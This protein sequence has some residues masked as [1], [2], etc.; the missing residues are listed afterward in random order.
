MN[1]GTFQPNQSTGIQN[2]ATFQESDYLYLPP[3]Q[4]ENIAA[5]HIGLP[6]E[7]PSVLSS[8]I[9]PIPT[10]S[11]PQ[12][13]L[14]R[15]ATQSAQTSLRDISND[16]PLPDN[17]LLNGLYTLPR[18][19]TPIVPAQ[20]WS[21]TPLLAFG[22]GLN[23]AGLLSR[24]REP[25]SHAAR[26]PECQVNQPRNQKKKQKKSAGEDGDRDLMG[27]L[28][29]SSDASKVKDRLQSLRD[30]V[31]DELATIA[32]DFKLDLT[33]LRTQLM[34][35][36]VKPKGTSRAPSLY[37]AKMKEARKDEEVQDELDKL[38]LTGRERQLWMQQHVRRELR[39]ITA[40]EEQELKDACLKDRETASIGVRVNY[41]ATC[42]DYTK[43]VERISTEVSLS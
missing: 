23:D 12:N 5:S 32:S 25:G 7:P 2:N 26:H 10:T 1:S 28:S 31:E 22:D 40:K 19:S 29:G 33:K 16:T 20:T 41:K 35:G 36:F 17:T 27:R 43:N 42:A 14:D 11:L 9:P 18:S 8:S 24:D 3:V 39:N 38:G 4:D 30:S 13:D 15:S 21:T 6:I 37:N 34:T